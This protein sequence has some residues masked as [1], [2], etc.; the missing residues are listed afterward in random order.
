MSFTKNKDKIMALI[1]AYCS[2]IPM[3]FGPSANFIQSHPLTTSLGV[4]G[5]DRQIMQLSKDNW[6]EWVGWRMSLMM[7]C[8]GLTCV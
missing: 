4:V 8:G 6:S 5:S 1:G 3:D 2:A 7:K